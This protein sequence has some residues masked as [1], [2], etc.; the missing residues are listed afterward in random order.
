MDIK[1]RPPLFA[2]E[3]PTPI[4]WS[5]RKLRLAT[6]GIILAGVLF[7]ATLLLLF[8]GGHPV[9]SLY[10]QCSVTNIEIELPFSYLRGHIYYPDC[11]TT[12]RS[13]E[14]LEELAERINALQQ[15]GKPYRAE[16]M[17][18]RYLLIEVESRRKTALFCIDSE[19]PAAAGRYN[20]YVLRYC[21]KCV[22]REDPTQEPRCIYF[23]FYLLKEIPEGEYYERHALEMD[24]EY[25]VTGRKNSWIFT[26]APGF[27]ECWKKRT[28]NSSCWAEVRSL[29]F[30]SGRKMGASL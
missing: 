20:S 5:K 21:G 15:E 2:D 1:G 14:S 28:I 25:E 7:A 11:V 10:A 18:D 26:A 17:S 24:V 12:F 4:P 29:P 8:A 9:S 19:K 30:L 22:P 6:A 3:L 27:T 23:P 13:F 16:V